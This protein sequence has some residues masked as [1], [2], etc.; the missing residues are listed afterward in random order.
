MQNLKEKMMN[1]TIFGATGKVGAECLKQSLADG[2]HV[3]VL[4]RDARKL[5]S[6]F[7]KI[8]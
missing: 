6:E 8:K 3:T 4:V 1:I 2:H 7:K 5:N